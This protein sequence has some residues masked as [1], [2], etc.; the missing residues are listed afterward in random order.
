MKLTDTKITR[1]EDGNFWVDIVE[2]SDEYEAWISHKE[3]G[4]STLAFGLPKTNTLY[5]I[6]NTNLVHSVFLHIVNANLE[7]YKA[8]YLEEV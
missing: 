8:I 1:Y 2:K 3:Y 7:R 5:D 6:E 4:I